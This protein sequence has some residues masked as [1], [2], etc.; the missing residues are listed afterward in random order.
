MGV[1]GVGKTT[2]ATALAEQ[3]GWDFV[4]G[5]DLHPPENLAAMRSGRPLTDA[6]RVPWLERI[7]AL[8]SEWAAQDRQGVVTCSALRRSYRDLL[9]DARPG[10]VFLHLVAD[11]E[12]LADRMARRTDHFMPEA[13]LDSQL[14]TLEPL[15]PDEPGCAVDAAGAVDEVVGRAVEGLGLP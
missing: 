15:E 7:G 9:R 14:A 3:L 5:D 4:E 10:V 13:L 8:L 12:R 11:P 6:D 2:V 1:S